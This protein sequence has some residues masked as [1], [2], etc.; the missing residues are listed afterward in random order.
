MRKWIR[1]AAA[2]AVAVVAV[3]TAAPA[4]M[5]GNLDGP[6]SLLQCERDQYNYALSVLGQYPRPAATRGED[7]GGGSF[8]H[9]IR[10]MQSG[11]GGN[12]L[13][14]Y[15]NCRIAGDNAQDGGATNVTFRLSWPAPNF[16]VNMGSNSLGSLPNAWR[17]DPWVDPVSGAT[18]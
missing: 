18:W 3:M 13:A 11:I 10:W 1:N 17:F 16:Q 9:R 2:G 7:Y 14:L 4:A 8:A 15:M 6:H 12:Y 5:A